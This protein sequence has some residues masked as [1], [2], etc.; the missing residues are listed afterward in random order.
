MGRLEPKHIE[1][2]VLFRDGLAVKLKRIV[3]PSTG[4]LKSLF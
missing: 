1:A 2:N 3:S 4:A